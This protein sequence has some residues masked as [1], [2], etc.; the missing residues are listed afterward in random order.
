MLQ[1]A[2][3]ASRTSATRDHIV[4]VASELFY[5]RGTRA[6]GIDEIIAEAGVAKATLYRH[7][8]GK[9][10]LIVAYLEAR[11]AHLE[12]AFSNCLARKNACF[13]DRVLAIFDD[14]AK[15]LKA[16]GFR[17][18]AF[19]MAVAEQNGSIRIRETA[20]AYKLFLRNQLHALLKGHVP[21]SGQ[22]ADQLMLVYE[23]AI[24]TAVLRL[25]SNPA[26]QARRCAKI[27][28]SQYKTTK[29]GKSA[30]RQK[31]RRE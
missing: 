18:C 24:A 4:G 14:L 28:L 12:Q 6:I 29:K 13:T 9:E 26:A 22:V 8:P 3:K 19:L 10:D 21:K 27:L 30:D 7:F 11:R 16:G 17:G 5:S 20:R 25:D 2:Q 15:N 23:G 31:K 1:D